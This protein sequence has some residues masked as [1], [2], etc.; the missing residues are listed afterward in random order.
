MHNNCSDL[1]QADR[2]PMQK[3]CSIVGLFRPNHPHGLNLHH[4][5]LK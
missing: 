1:C 3:C 2:S 5:A 4:Y